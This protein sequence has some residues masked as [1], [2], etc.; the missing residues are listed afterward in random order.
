MNDCRA[1]VSLRS[2]I[3]VPAPAV[4][5]LLVSATLPAA[6]TQAA[7]SVSPALPEALRPQSEALV[8]EVIDGDTLVLDG[9]EEVRLVGIQAPKLPLGRPDFESWPLAQEAK[10]A[11]EDLAAGQRVSLA[12]GERRRDRHGRLLAHLLDEESRW[13]Q[14]EML[15]RGLARVYSFED[16]R[17]AIAE[18]LALEAEAREARRGLWADPFYMVRSAEEAARHVGGFELVEGEVLAVGRARGRVFLN[19]GEDYKRD[20]TAVLEPAARR[21]FER[22]GRA[23]TAYRGRRVRVRGWVQS[24]NGPM[25]EVTHPEQIEVLD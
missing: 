20:F 8:R 22:E 25:I 19:F 10:Q 13:L 5:A 12:F 23:P 9:G 24:L 21:L 14:G 3:L 17:V 16:N 15:A 4:V 18:M 2:L 7:S 11:L 6:P 1:H